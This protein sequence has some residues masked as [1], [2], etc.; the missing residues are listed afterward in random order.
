MSSGS[1]ISH[2]PPAGLTG[3]EVIV[4]PVVLLKVASFTVKVAW[5]KGTT[6][7]VCDHPFVSP[8]KVFVV[9]LNPVAVGALGKAPYAQA[10]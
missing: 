4:K 8:D 9:K 5:A 6:P 7:K 10:S 1:K 3:P 2:L